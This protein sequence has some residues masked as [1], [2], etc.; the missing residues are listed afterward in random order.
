MGTVFWRSLL[1]DEPLAY[2]PLPERRKEAESFGLL[3]VMADFG[4]CS[5][6]I[7]DLRTG[8][9]LDP[10]PKECIEQ[11]GG[12]HSGLERECWGAVCGAQAT[13]GCC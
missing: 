3:S 11:L 4:K 13:I 7:M 2:R 6:R 12:K 5:L 9:F 8:T 10:A 1:R